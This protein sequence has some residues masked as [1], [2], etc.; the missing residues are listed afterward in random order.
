MRMMRRRG[1]ERTGR[2]GRRGN[3]VRLK[4]LGGEYLFL[5]LRERKE[6]VLTGL[7]CDYSHLDSV[8]SVSVK[9]EEDGEVVVVSGGDDMTVKVWRLENGIVAGGNTCVLFRVLFLLIRL[10]NFCSKTLQEGTRT[11]SYS[12]SEYVSYHDGIDLSIHKSILYSL[13]GFN[14]QRLQIPFKRQRYLRSYHHISAHQ[15]SVETSLEFS[16]GAMLNPERRWR[17][18]GG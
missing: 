6:G 15:R 5:V 9:M 10:T 12:Q 11:S 14:N 7:G 8:R 4:L 2:R 13:N 3:G 1:G 16:L 18:V 17:R